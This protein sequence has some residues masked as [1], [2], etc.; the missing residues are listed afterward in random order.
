MT[1]T[2]HAGGLMHILKQERCRV[3]VGEDIVVNILT[4]LASEGFNQALV[5]H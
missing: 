1:G 2:P 3:D 5:K 4:E